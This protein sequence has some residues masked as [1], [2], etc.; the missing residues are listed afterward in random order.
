V[1]YLAKQNSPLLLSNVGD[2]ASQKPEFFH[3][4]Q[5]TTALYAIAAMMFAMACGLLGVSDRPDLNLISPWKSLYVWNSF[6]AVFCLVLAFLAMVALVAISMLHPSTKPLFETLN[7]VL[8]GFAPVAAA[9]H[10]FLRKS[11]DAA[12][13]PGAASKVTPTA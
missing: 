8:G 13:S 1:L 3:N 9:G 11:I 7:I 12:S 2:I 10:F 5:G 4:V 6:L